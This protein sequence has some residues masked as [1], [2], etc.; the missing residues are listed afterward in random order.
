MESKCSKPR[1]AEPLCSFTPLPL[2]KP[3]VIP[4]SHLIDVGMAK[5]NVQREW[6]P[7]APT[8]Q[9]LGGPWSSAGMLQAQGILAASLSPPPHPF[10]FQRAESQDGLPAR[11]APV[12]ACSWW[13]SIWPHL[14]PPRLCSTKCGSQ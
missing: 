14:L 9:V 7:V 8:P 10:S 6:L 4:T 11:P 1:R 2:G 3:G 5:G 12:P 13:D